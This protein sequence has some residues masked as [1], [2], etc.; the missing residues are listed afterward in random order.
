MGRKQDES[1]SSNSINHHGAT[2]LA[3][4]VCS[5]QVQPSCARLIPELVIHSER[6][7]CE[8]YKGC[9]P[10]S[11]IV[12]SESPVVAGICLL[13]LMLG[14]SAEPGESSAVPTSFVCL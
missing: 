3:S 6:I 11:G 12:L 10:L 4:I 8:V 1:A 9:D 13:Y 14:V 7:S 2:S 5:K